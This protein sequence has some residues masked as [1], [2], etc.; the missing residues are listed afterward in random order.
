MIYCIEIRTHEHINLVVATL[1]YALDYAINQ[2]L[3]L[4]CFFLV[5]Y[6][7]SLAE[8]I[9]TVFPMFC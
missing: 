2:Y 7:N 3:T 1:I 6:L 8:I 9:E 5:E 4:K